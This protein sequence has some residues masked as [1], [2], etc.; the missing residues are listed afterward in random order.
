MALHLAHEDGIPAAE[1][2]VDVPAYSRAS[3]HKSPLADMFAVSSDTAL[4][5]SRRSPCG[6]ELAHEE[7]ITA[8]E[9][10]VDVPAYS[11]ASSLPQITVGKYIC[12]SSDTALSR[13][14]RSPCGSELAHED[15][16]TAAEICVDVPTYSRASSHKSTLANI[17]AAPL[18]PRFL[19]AD[20]APVGV[21][22][23]T[24]KAF[25]TLGIYRA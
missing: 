15:G 7:G 8:A 13:S 6:S 16:I 19:A 2:C 22:L 12:G 24:K 17:F 14:R 23:L 1:H 9:N 5:R 10:C 21:S 11:R 20:T 18:T 25:Q 4:S 3:S